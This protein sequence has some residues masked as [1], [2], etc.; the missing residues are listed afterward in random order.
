MA[1]LQDE[2]QKI[3]NEINTTVDNNE[4][5]GTNNEI[6]FRLNII[7]AFVLIEQKEY[8]SAIINA[9]EALK[10]AITKQNKQEA[11]HLLHQIYSKTNNKLKAYKYKKLLEKTEKE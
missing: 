6:N 5:I 2:A 8:E 7:N 4:V 10:N 1:K 11:Y 3:L 9:K